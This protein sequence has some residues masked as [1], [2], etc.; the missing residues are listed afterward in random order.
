MTQEKINL[1]ETIDEL[2]STLTNEGYCLF[3]F[4]EDSYDAKMQLDSEQTFV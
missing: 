1:K 4:D 2:K 3:V